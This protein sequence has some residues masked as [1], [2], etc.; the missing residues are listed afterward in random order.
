MEAGTQEAIAGTQLAAD[1]KTHLNAIIEVSEE[2][3]ELIQ[4]ITRATG[5][6]MAGAEAIAKVM[7]QVSD[8]SEG[9]AHKSVE[10]RSSL[11][12][13]AIAVNQLQESVANFRS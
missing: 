12:G 6:Q 5:K 3:N 7:Q 13:L 10:V 2:M 1:A 4:T 9:T 11:D 8:I